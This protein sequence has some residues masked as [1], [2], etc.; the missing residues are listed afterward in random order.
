MPPETKYAQSP[1]GAVAYQ[2]FGE[3]EIDLVFV[4]QWAT[5]IDNF[6]DEPSAVRYFDR[7]ASFS[8]VILFDKRG[9]GVSDPAPREK[10]P[11]VDRWMEDI[12]TVMDAAGSERAAIVG[13]AEGGSMAIMFAAT[14]P[15]RTCSLVL[16]NSL[17]R[18][19]H[20]PDYPIGFKEEE[21]ERI[22][23]M[24][25]AQHGTTGRVV[26]F[27]APSVA[28]DVR[29]RRWWVKFQRST[30]APKTVAAGYALQQRVDVTSVLSTINVPSLV[31][32]RKGNVYHK[33]EFGRYLAD[34]IPDATMIELD[35]A[36]S[37]PFHTG[38]FT[39]ILD[40]VEL[41][42]TGE[43]ALASSERRLATVLF[44]DIVDSTRSAA[45]IGDQRWL[46][47][48]SEVNRMSAQHVERFGGETIDTTGDGCVAI[49]DSPAKAVTA[50]R[51][52]LAEVAHL[53]VAMRA[54]LHTGEITLHDG[55]IGGV[56]VHIAARVMG[57]A[58]DGGIAASSTVRDLTVGSSIGYEPMGLQELKGV[59]G[60]WQL[61]E[62][63]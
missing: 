50:T 56:G 41:F 62:V 34:R 6:W 4:T 23:S 3:G 33:I 19:F 45:T 27:T 44:T 16:I 5:N 46:D 17:A 43:R 55:D 61:F 2:V 47:V 54:G 1:D 18:A 30:M 36:D 59:P 15:E 13:D 10:M 53:G 58:P 9:T 49:F 11:R 31:V 63:I 24:F 14:Y 25:L 57:C 38:D 42:V 35:G 26:E 28:D 8:R 29:F 39:E 21:M 51:E 20:G 48:L 7:L 40:H 37:L 12:L 22:A 60:E 52:I 32:H